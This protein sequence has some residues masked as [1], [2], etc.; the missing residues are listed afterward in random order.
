MS[1]ERIRSRLA[2]ADEAPGIDSENYRLR[3]LSTP[4]V[5]G[6]ETPREPEARFPFRDNAVNKVGLPRGQRTLAP[7][8]CNSYRV[9]FDASHRVLAITIGSSNI[10]SAS[11]DTAGRRGLKNPRAAHLRYFEGINPPTSEAQ[12][13]FARISCS[14]LPTSLAR[15]EFQVFQLGEQ[16]GAPRAVPEKRGFTRMVA[17]LPLITR[18]VPYFP[19]VLLQRPVSSTKR[20][21]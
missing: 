12:P 5:I 21:R 18:L 13:D 16:L 9:S 4:R 20:R 15:T 2:P 7:H 19:S 3:E 14:R 1:S 17:R 11:R 6:T 10:C 8:I